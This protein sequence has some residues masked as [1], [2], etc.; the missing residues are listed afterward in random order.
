MRCIYC[1]KR[2]VGLDLCHARHPVCAD[3]GFG[4]Q[5]E[6]IVVREPAPKRRT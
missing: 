1:A 6:A 5:L 4:H 3:H 2:A